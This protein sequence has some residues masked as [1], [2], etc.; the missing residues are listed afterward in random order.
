MMDG[1]R[2]ESLA[3]TALR[4]LGFLAVAAAIVLAWPGIQVARADEPDRS[5]QPEARAGV[6]PDASFEGF[7]R[8]L[9]A[10]GKTVPVVEDAGPTCSQP[11]QMSAE[12]AQRQAYVRLQA[13]LIAAARAGTLPAPPEGVVV[14]NGSGYNYRPNTPGMPAVGTQPGAPVEPPPTPGP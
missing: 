4:G 14:L 13:Q 1:D 5:V 7:A 6:A 9:S 8:H 12:M 10:R 3:R 2:I 11:S